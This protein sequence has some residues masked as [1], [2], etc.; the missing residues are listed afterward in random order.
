M[1]NYGF[2][3]S[4]SHFSYMCCCSCLNTQVLF[5]YGRSSHFGD[6]GLKILWIRHI[7]TL[8][9]NKGY[10]LHDK[11]NDNGPNNNLNNLYGNTIMKRI[12]IM[13][14]SSYRPTWMLSLLKHINVSRCHIL[15][16]PRIISI[17]HAYSPFPHLMKTGTINL[18]LHLLKH[19][20]IVNRMIYNW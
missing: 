2:L 7:Q 6:M 20:K 4:M 13:E 10:C 18:A 3:K 15:L 8:I 19:P 11:P 17:R 1:D 16:L 14:P 9:L 12:V 5:Y